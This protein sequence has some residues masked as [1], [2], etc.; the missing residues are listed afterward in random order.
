MDSSS[1]LGISNFQKQKDYVSRFVQALDIGPHQSQIGVVTYSSQ[2]HNEFNLNT[3]HNKHELVTAIQ[4][5][6]YHPGGTRTDLALKYV[7]RNSFTRAAGDRARVANVLIFTAAEQSDQPAL[8][9][10][11]AVHIHKVNIRVYALGIGSGVDRTELGYIA[12]DSHHIFSMLNF[13]VLHNLQAELK[14]TACIEGTCIIWTIPC[15]T[16]LQAYV[17]GEGLDQPAHPRSLIRA[18]ALR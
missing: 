16:C 7:Q 12:S 2:P 4:N 5:I 10:V 18:F 8:T 9:R 6:K 13:D 17:D 14:R 1:T 15:K 3:F 11:E